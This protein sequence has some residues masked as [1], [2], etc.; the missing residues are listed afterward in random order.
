MEALHAT[1]ELNTDAEKG[2]AR[3]RSILLLS[4]FLIALPLAAQQTSERYAGAVLQGDAGS[5]ALLLRLDGGG[6]RW[7]AVPPHVDILR[8]TP[9]EKDLGRASE[10]L[11]ESMRPGDRI[12]ARGDSAG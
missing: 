6:E 12:V 2:R 3:M 4:A 7:V 5:R 9:G 10:L 8:I 11:F 1:G